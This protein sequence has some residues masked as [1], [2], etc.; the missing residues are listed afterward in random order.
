[1]QHVTTV[2]IAAPD[3]D[4]GPGCFFSKINVLGDGLESR[5]VNDRIAEMRKIR[6]LLESL[7]V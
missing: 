4:F 2:V 6:L 7:L 5:P 1:M 3:D